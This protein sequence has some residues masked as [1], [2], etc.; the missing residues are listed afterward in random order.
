MPNDQRARKAESARNTI[1]I[2]YRRSDTE[3]YA[4]RLQDA[5]KAY[6]GDH[7]VFRDVGGITPGE[8]FTE[9]IEETMEKAGAL[10]VLIGPD[11]LASG[12]GGQPR[13]HESGDHLAG[14]IRAALQK[15]SVIVPVLVEGASMPREEDLPDDLTELSR[16]N[17]VS[18]SDAGWTDD[19]IRL[20]KVLAM[21]ISGSVA[22]RKLRLLKRAVISLLVFSM[23]VTLGLIFFDVNDLYDASIRPGGEDPILWAQLAAL[24]NP[25]SAIIAGGL[26]MWNKSWIDRFSRKF[27]VAA[28]ILCALGLFFTF[29]FYLYDDMFQNG[30]EYHVFLAT[31]TIN[32]LMLGLLAQSGLKPSEIIH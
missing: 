1:F 32:I 6:F 23:I 2:S 20:A 3:G 15:K 14:E 31:S 25:I 12:D 9:K 8:D 22:E 29:I 19:T 30:D 21:D 11:W 18:I 17:A 24:I 5:L 13:L 28:V 16:R 27:V 4:G 7:R 26:L 10:I